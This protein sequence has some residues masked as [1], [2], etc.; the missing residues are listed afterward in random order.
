[1][2]FVVDEDFA[3][4]LEEF[5]TP[6]DGRPAEED[7]LN[8]Y[9]NRLPGRLLD[10][11]K[12]YGFCSVKD[13]MFWI[14]NPDD[15]KDAMDQWLAFTDIPKEDNYHVIARSGFGDLF[16][17]GERTGSKYVIE[18]RDGQIFSG[19]DDSKRIASGDADKAVSIFF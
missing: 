16:L 7:T 10:Y 6:R 2:K 14:V 17:W 18:I 9:R 15:F 3:C 5:G 12:E 8:K 1:M 4:F 11:W 19:R 13:G